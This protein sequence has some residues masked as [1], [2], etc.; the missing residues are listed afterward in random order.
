MFDTSNPQQRERLLVILAGIVLLFVVLWQLPAQFNSVRDLKRNKDDL[1]QKI[2]DHHRLAPDGQRIQSRLSAFE[3]QALAASGTPQGS[4]AEAR[5]RAWLRGL[6]NS[7]G[8][9]VTGDTPPTTAVGATGDF[10]HARHTFTINGE[11]RLDQ[12]AEFLRRFHRTEYL[13][14][15][16]TFSPQPVQNRPGIFRVTFRVETLS[17]PQVRFV[18]MP[19][20]EGTTST[21]EERQMLTAIRNRGILSEYSPPR[22]LTLVSATPNSVTLTWT[23]DD[24]DSHDIRYKLRTAPDAEANWTLI[25]ATTGYIDEL[26]ANTNYDFQIRAVYDEE[27]DAWSITTPLSTERPAVESPPFE[28]IVFCFLQTIVESDGRPQAWINHRTT[29]RTHYLFEGGSFTLDG[30]LCIIR[31]IDVDNERIL[32]EIGGGLYSLGVG[33][34][35]DEVDPVELAEQ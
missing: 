30:V 4:E 28:D 6:A 9:N 18:N 32:V 25:E 27:P 13:H 22:P 17:L 12:I 3:N 2:A 29:G 21:A 11:G 10:G 34:H 8:L 5:Y 35:F 14:I 15:L 33:Q 31:R 26:F 7:A 20:T 24:A 23:A 16:K 19:S 1:D